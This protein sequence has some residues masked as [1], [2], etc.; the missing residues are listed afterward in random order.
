MSQV[1]LFVYADFRE[2]SILEGGG[3]VRLCAEQAGG[4]IAV[5]GIEA[6]VVGHGAVYIVC[7]VQGQTAKIFIGS[8]QIAEVGAV[9]AGILKLAF[10]GA[11]DCVDTGFDAGEGFFQLLGPAVCGGDYLM[12]STFLGDGQGIDDGQYADYQHR[13]KSTQQDDG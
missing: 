10:E 3:L 6:D 11:G 9:A 7:T 5:V 2:G 8:L 12:G 1:V 13:G 4:G